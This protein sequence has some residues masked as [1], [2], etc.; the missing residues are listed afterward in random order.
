MYYLAEVFPKIRDIKFPLTRDQLLLLMVAINQIILGADIFLAHSLSGEITP[1]EWIPIIFGPV[2]GILLI[3]AGVIALRTRPFAVVSG[4][5]VFTASI[6]VGALGTYYHLE[7]ALV[8][9]A[10]LTEFIQFDIFAWAPPAFGPIS[11][12]GLGIFGFIISLTELPADSGTLRVVGKYKIQLPFPKTNIYFFL[13]GLGILATVL[14]ST[15]DHAR[16]GFTNPWLWFPTLTGIF[17][18]VASLAPG[19][20]GENVRQEIKPYIA[21][22]ALM[23]LAGMTGAFLHVQVDLTSS[24]EVIQERFLR[25]APVM[26]PLNFAN[27]GVIAL[28]ILLDPKE[29][30]AT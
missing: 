29:V 6:V 10:P 18:T 20:L 16:T 9:S 7:R 4:M 28:I 19:F 24:F 26:A 11:F 21:A 15:I 8:L 12:I 17:A 22:M 25:G 1:Y 2:A 30:T 3:F 23:I 5:V 13:V 27:M 14:S